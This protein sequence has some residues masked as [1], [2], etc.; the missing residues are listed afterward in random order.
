MVGSSISDQLRV[1]KVQIVWDE[2]KK[3]Y[4][5]KGFNARDIVIV[6]IGIAAFG[7]DEATDRAYELFPNVQRVEA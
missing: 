7:L 5:L 2:T 3:L 6:E 4:K 1:K